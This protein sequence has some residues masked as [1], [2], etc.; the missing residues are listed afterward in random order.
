ES[1]SKCLDNG[2]IS[3]PGPVESLLAGVVVAIQ[4]KNMMTAGSQSDV[5]VQSITLAGQFLKQMRQQGKNILRM[6]GSPIP[7]LRSRQRRFHSSSDRGLPL[8]IEFADIVH[9]CC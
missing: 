1:D 7:V 6:V 2:L 8:F 5:I 9:Q 3:A 4:C